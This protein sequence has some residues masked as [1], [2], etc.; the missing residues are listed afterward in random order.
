[1]AW[2]NRGAAALFERLKELAPALCLDP[3]DLRQVLDDEQGLGR[4]IA[5]RDDLL[6][7]VLTGLYQL[8]PDPVSY[9]HGR[10]LL[11]GAAVRRPPGGGD[12]ARRARQRLGAARSASATAA[13][14]SPLE[15]LSLPFAA[16]G[17]RASRWCS[18]RPRTRPRE[19]P[20]PA[21]FS[22]LFAC[23]ARTETRRLPTR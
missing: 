14:S 11:A 7:G 16:G 12:R 10:T 19:A 13:P 9:G 8:E 2:P 6:E 15:L 3:L 4:L 1:M 18:R 22:G 20:R 17:L 5:N 23:S 21:Y